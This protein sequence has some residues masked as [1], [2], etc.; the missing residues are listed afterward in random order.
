MSDQKQAATAQEL[1]II[2]SIVKA[3]QNGAI[4]RI[5]VLGTVF[6][7]D[8]GDTLANLGEH[9]EGF[10][11]ALFHGA[12]P[13]WENMTPEIWKAQFETYQL[14]LEAGIDESVQVVITAFTI[15]TLF[16]YQL[17]YPDFTFEGDQPQRW[18]E[19]LE[20]AFAPAQ[21]DVATAQ[22][23]ATE[24]PPVETSASNGQEVAEQAKEVIATTPNSEAVERFRSWIGS[25]V[26][27]N[28]AIVKTNR[29]LLVASQAVNEA[30]GANTEALEANTDFLQNV[31]QFVTAVLQAGGTVPALTETTTA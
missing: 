25:T 4:V 26:R 28:Q 22:A 18:L 1:T 3:E 2:S 7:A 21:E 19:Q 5:P 20:E 16:A 17:F 31:E 10:K 24:L 15:G 30:L 14:A 8:L 13:G 23:E 6:T 9:A 11:A 29:A 27:T 12:V